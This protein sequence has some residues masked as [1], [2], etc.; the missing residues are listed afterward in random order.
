MADTGST[1][2]RRGGNLCGSEFARLAQNKKAYAMN[3]QLK[4][5]QAGMILFA[6]TVVLILPNLTRVFS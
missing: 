1:R 3:R 2:Y 5:R 4:L 6:T